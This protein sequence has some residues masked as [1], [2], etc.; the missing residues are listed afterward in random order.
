MRR[1]SGPRFP[2]RKAILHG[3]ERLSIFSIHYL[4][5]HSTPREASSTGR[6]LSTD[7][8]QLDDCGLYIP[9]A[10]LHV[11][12]WRP[13]ERA[14]V[15]HAHGDHARR[16]SRRY[17][18]SRRG[19]GVLRTRMGAD[20]RI[21]TL[22]W[23][24][25][26]RIGGATLSLHPAGHILGSAQVRIEVG[27]EVW[28]VS[29]DYKLAKDPTT[30]PFEPVSCDVFISE[31]TFGLPVYRWP[32]PQEVFAS[33]VEWWEENAKVGR[34]SVLFGYSLGKAQRLLAGVHACTGAH[35]APGPI[36][37][38]GAVHRLLEPYRDA[39]VV[40][41]AVERAHRTSAKAAEGRALVVAPPSAGGTPWIRAFSP[42]STAFASGWMRFRGTRRRRGG[43]RG[44]V[45]SDHVDWSGLLD[46][47][48]ATGAHR[49]GLTHG[50]TSAAARYL[51]E[52][53]GLDSWEMV[54]RFQGEAGAED[55]DRDQGEDG[56]GAQ[57]GSG[58]DPERAREP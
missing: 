31:C 5:M 17:L 25:R 13:V 57:K 24:E 35:G 52:V 43:D 29:G 4:N 3:S 46:A 48:E 2:T 1:L 32:D 33:I 37:V 54:T 18:T 36:L 42:A 27:G 53:R 49:V 40:L 56:G 9:A 55:D 44:F 6:A 8:I 26:I 39:G 20:A 50:N 23:G 12:P 16:G 28:V 11:D 22:D 51:R 30:T 21:E 47:V 15:T 58:G 19:Q 7:L 10:D 45:L 38:H 14:V 41:P 34:T